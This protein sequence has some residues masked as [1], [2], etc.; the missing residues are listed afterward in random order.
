VSAAADLSVIVPVRDGAETLGAAIASV[1]DRAEGLLE[2]I[3]VDDGSSDGSA[4]LARSFG[5]AVQVI[6]SRGAGIG[7]GDAGM[8]AGMASA[9]PAA[10]R[11]S[12]VGAARGTLLSFLDA[13]DE[14]AAPR[15]D[16]RRALLDTQR[17][18][19]VLGA[20]HVEG[21][22]GRK[23]TGPLWSFGAALMATTT[24]ARVGPIDESLTRGEDIE[25]FSRARDTGVPLLH[26]DDVVL[27][28]RRRADSLSLDP[29]RGLLEGLR[30]TIA[31]KDAA[32]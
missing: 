31:R 10:A 15:P 21:R 4:E 7:A 27:H 28:Y 23:A 1:L 18:A 30:A 29:H 20:V 26:V 3:V 32:R 5:P 22:G 11:N 12:G 24:F 16:P 14:W 25:W 9:G 13:D 19:I 8:S 17:D 6:A 2:V